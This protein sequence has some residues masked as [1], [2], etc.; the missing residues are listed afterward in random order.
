MARTTVGIGPPL[1]LLDG[2]TINHANEVIAEAMAFVRSLGSEFRGVDLRGKTRVTDD[3]EEI[4][5]N[6]A[7]VA[8]WLADGGRD[9]FSSDQ[10][11]ADRCA[12]IIT[13]EIERRLAAAARRKPRK[14]RRGAKP[15]SKQ[16]QINN[17][18]GGALRLAMY[19]YIEYVRARILQG[20]LADGS[21]P[22]ELSVAYAAH[23]RKEFGFTHPI[24]V[25]SGQ[26]LDNLDSMNTGNI[27]LRKK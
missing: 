10:I 15:R 8:Q 16:R 2:G 14:T 4:G 6:N 24:G 13:A 20:R 7:T 25:A 1:T 22:D 3:D 27:R 23:K 11:I 19:A 9:F 12:G 5:L 18:T 21:G 26:L 17:I